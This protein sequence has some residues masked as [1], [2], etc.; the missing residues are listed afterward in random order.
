M[1]KQKIGAAAVAL[2][3]VIVIIALAVRLSNH[4]DPAKESSAAQSGGSLIVIDPT[5]RI[6]E[7]QEAS[8]ETETSDPHPTDTEY[9]GISVEYTRLPGS[10]ILTG[11]D[12]GITPYVS[13]YDGNGDGIDDQ[14]QI[15]QGA[16]AYL[17]NKPA[18]SAS[19]YFKGGYPFPD[20][21]GNWTGVCTDV[22]NMGLLAAGY[23]I[24]ALLEK[25]LETHKTD[26]YKD[27]YEAATDDP[28]M[29]CRRARM[30]YLFFKQHA[31]S[32]ST[33]PYDLDAWQPGD[34]V[35]FA[36]TSG[37]WNGHIA[38]ISDRRAEDGVAYVLH[39][40]STGQT[41]YEEDYLVSTTKKIYAHFR[42][43]GY[44]GE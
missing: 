33:D 21:Q 9:V 20:A 36:G 42:Y 37:L 4:A 22:I 16:K 38:L 31:E 6:P 30:L 44:K 3:A 15:L 25:D 29:N 28:N 32:L 26:W 5:I 7:S 19:S 35:I 13:P 17:A 14:T 10:R 41:L 40:A 27:Y 12:F 39:H 23:D 18:Y 11:E 43:S 1:N 2:L 8:S 24:H 34:I